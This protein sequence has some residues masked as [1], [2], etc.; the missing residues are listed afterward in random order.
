MDAI[1]AELQQVPPTSTRSLFNGSIYAKRAFTY[2]W[3][4]HYW[5]VS[6]SCCRQDPY[7]RLTEFAYF[8]THKQFCELT[9]NGNK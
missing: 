4:E 8:Y 6:V 9:Q 3:Y 2:D 5:I 1:V 7:L